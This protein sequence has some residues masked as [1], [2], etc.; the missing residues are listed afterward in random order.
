MWYVWDLQSPLMCISLFTSDKTFSPQISWYLPS[1][2]SS[3]RVPETKATPEH[4]WAATMFHCVLHMVCFILLPPD[5]LLVHRSVKL[6]FYF[7]APQNRILKESSVAYLYGSEQTRAVFS[8]GFGSV[9]E[10]VLEFRHGLPALTNSCCRSFVITWGFWPPASNSFL[11]MPYGHIQCLSL[12]FVVLSLVVEVSDLL[13]LWTILLTYNSN[14][15][16]KATVNKHQ[17]NP[18]I[19]ISFWITWCI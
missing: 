8:Q 6:W 10:C 12:I 5:I 4:H 9:E 11:F 3:F 2:C 13:T 18:G 19:L 15:Q 7:S 14:M 1:T 17:A 16:W